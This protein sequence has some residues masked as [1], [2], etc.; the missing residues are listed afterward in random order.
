MAHAIAFTTFLIRLDSDNDTKNQGLAT[1]TATA[2]PATATATATYLDTFPIQ[3]FIK[4]NSTLPA[5]DRTYTFPY[6]LI[7]RPKAYK[8]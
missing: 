4:H 2:I 6:Y 7:R 1:D 5:T 3:H 8:L